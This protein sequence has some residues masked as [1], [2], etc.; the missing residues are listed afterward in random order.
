[1]ELRQVSVGPMDNNAYL[2]AS[3]GQGLLVDAAADPAALRALIG[4]TPVGTIVTTHRHPDH[5]GAL[6]DLAAHTGARLVAGTPDVAAIE[7]TTGVTI[8]QGVWDG[9]A[10]QVGSVS[11][12]VIGLVGHT[13]GSIALAHSPAD[14]PVQL[15]S[16]DSLFPGG[17]GRTLQP[18]DFESLM[19]D[20]ETKVF[21][22]FGDDTC[23]YPGHGKPTTLG[24]ERPHLPEWWARWW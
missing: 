22:R 12:E 15:F 4:D 11:L 23:V 6:A 8:D 18:E 24:V 10:V 19:T 2:I 21:A 13:P 7:Q 9:D 14:G 1:M 3:D 16:G 20:L 5:L 17:P